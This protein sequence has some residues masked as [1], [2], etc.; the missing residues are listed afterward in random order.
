M[1]VGQITCLLISIQEGNLGCSL[2][3]YLVE[4]LKTNFHSHFV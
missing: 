2:L 1:T 4:L 3:Y